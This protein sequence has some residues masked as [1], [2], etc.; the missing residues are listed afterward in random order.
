MSNRGTLSLFLI[1]VMFI[2]LCGCTAKNN[3]LTQDNITGNWQVI[4]VGMDLQ[5]KQT[6]D[7][8]IIQTGDVIKFF[9][10]TIE[11]GHGYLFNETI[12]VTTQTGT[13]WQDFG[14]LLISVVNNTVMRAVPETTALKWVSFEKLI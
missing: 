3:P 13:E 8:N 12:S 9:R 6:Y 5:V 14:V 4:E 7:V 10:G 2:V 11:L 1:P